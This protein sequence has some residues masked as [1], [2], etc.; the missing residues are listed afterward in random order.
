MFHFFTSHVAKNTWKNQIRVILCFLV[1][2]RLKNISVLA[3]GYNIP[4]YSKVFKNI[5][6]Y[7][8]IFQNVQEYSIISGKFQNIQEYSKI[9]RNIPKYSGIFQNVQ[10]YS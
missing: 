1:G 2:T 6:K 8:G 5:P 10:E 3:A 9:F 7:S 4:E